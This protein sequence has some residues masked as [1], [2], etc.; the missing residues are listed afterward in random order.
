[1]FKEP[2]E[3]DNASSLALRNWKLLL[4]S[5]PEV[6]FAPKSFPGQLKGVPFKLFVG[7]FEEM[8]KS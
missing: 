5:V 6:M 7:Q 2:G 4:E 3:W 1:M 8:K